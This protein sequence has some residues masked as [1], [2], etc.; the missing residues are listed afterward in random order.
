V[1]RPEVVDSPLGSRPAE[2][3][4]ETPT[5]KLVDG[6]REQLGMSVERYFAGVDSIATYRC[7]DTGYMFYH[8]D[9]TAG[10]DAFYQVL[11]EFPWF[12]QE[13]KWEHAKALEHVEAG[14]RVLDIGC[15]T[16]NFLAAARAKGASVAGIELNTKSVAVAQGRGLDVTPNLV[17]RYAEGREE[18][19]DVVCTFQVLE[20]IPRPK[21]FLT[22]C[23]RLL[24]KG[25]LLVVGVPNNDGFL[26]YAD[27]AVLNFPPHHMA[28]WT[29]ES[30]EALQK[31]FPL[32]VVRTEREPLTVVDWYLAVMERRYLPWRPLRTL[33][34]RIGGSSLA[35]RIVTARAAS[36]PGHTILYVY[37]K[38]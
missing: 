16:G 27:D 10:D 3:V 12:Y 7:P 32:E 11:Q 18:T 2:L 26:K 15:G 35:R 8:P 31:L 13:D 38:V 24:R 21:S 20:H 37:K 29:A 14:S 17:E 1:K 33:Y 22:A 4:G 28:L 23:V 9:S 25:G 19:F 30:L 36:I 5:S 6:Y 34:H